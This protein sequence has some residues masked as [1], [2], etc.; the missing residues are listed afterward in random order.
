[1]QARGASRLRGQASSFP[2]QKEHR[3]SKR[4][5]CREQAAFPAQS[6][7]GVVL[8]HGARK[9]PC[10]PGARSVYT[11]LVQPRPAA[12]PS[13][14]PARAL[15]R[16]GL[17]APHYPRAVQRPS[18]SFKV[19]TRGLLAGIRRPGPAGP[20]W[21][22]LQTKRLQ[23]EG[24]G[25]ARPSADSARRAPQSRLGLRLRVEPAS[26]QPISTAASPITLKGGLPGEGRHRG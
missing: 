6:T 23:C 21:A 17:Q 7:P 8:R 13:V 15:G 20:W 1:M 11:V 22:G 18:I 9:K 24:R 5:R 10:H 2:V 26:A 25:E 3:C 16:L 4:P 19:G 12:A 14:W